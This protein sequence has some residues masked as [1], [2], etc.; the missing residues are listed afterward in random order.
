MLKRQED[1]SLVVNN[2]LAPLMEAVLADYCRGY[3]AARLAEVLSLMTI[4][5]DRCGEA[6]NPHIPTLLDN[7]FQCTLD[8]INKEFF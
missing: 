5:I 6:L 3:P 8:M 4:I 2:L 1:A 7:V